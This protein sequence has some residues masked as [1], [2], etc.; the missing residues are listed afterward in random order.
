MLSLLS[1]GSRGDRARVQSNGDVPMENRSQPQELSAADV[2][3]RSRSRSHSRSQAWGQLKDPVGVGRRLPGSSGGASLSDDGMAI[4]SD[5]ASVRSRLPSPTPSP[6]QEVTAEPAPGAKKFRRLRIKNLDSSP[7]ENGGAKSHGHVPAAS[8]SDTGIAAADA[9]SASLAAEVSAS[10]SHNKRHCWTTA[11]YKRMEKDW[12]MNPQYATSFLIQKVM[13]EGSFGI[14]YKGVRLAQEDA[15][16]GE[17]RDVAIKIM[18]PQRLALVKREVFILCVLAGKSNIVE[19]LDVTIDWATNVPSLIFEYVEH[20]DPATLFPRIPVTTAID[21]M[22]QLLTALNHCHTYGILHRDIK[23]A[24]VVYSLE[25]RRLKLIDWGTAELFVVGR[26]MTTRV[27]TRAFRAPELLA[28]YVFYDFS[29]DMWGFGVILWQ[30]M[31]GSK[32]PL[33]GYGA[34]ELDQLTKIAEVLGRTAFTKFLKIFSGKLKRSS[35]ETDAI[36]K[37]CHERKDFA[38]RA[39]VSQTARLKTCNELGLFKVLDQILN[40]DPSKRPMAYQALEHAIFNS[41][42]EA[43]ADE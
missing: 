22:F 42:R 15:D 23:P 14:V 43:C 16:H 24:N 3:Q 1:L 19:L 8:S 37:V 10:A 35:T 33:F 6:T 26:G 2:A 34:D 25:H 4:A 7:V 12:A 11:Y 18:K 21:Y 27:G 30:L 41:R 32:E 28:G 29:V 9:D 17:Q 20:E 5:S 40:F 31:I 39:D 38:S 36:L 13:G